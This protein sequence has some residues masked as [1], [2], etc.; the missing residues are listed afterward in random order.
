MNKANTKNLVIIGVVI[1][2]LGIAC[3]YYVT[4]D[5]SSSDLLVASAATTTTS[6]DGG[7][8]TALQELKHISLDGAIFSDPAWL[9]LNDF[10]QQ[11]APQGAGRPNPFAPLGAVGSTTAGQ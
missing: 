5:Q 10:S 3:Y 2:A 8:L 1:V 9:S 7:L 4:R 6:V 11:I